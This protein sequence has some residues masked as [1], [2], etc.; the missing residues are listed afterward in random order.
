[1]FT[2]EE[3]AAEIAHDKQWRWGNSLFVDG[4]CVHV[5]EV[6][7]HT[8]EVIAKIEAMIAAQANSLSSAQ[9]VAPV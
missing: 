1:M 7:S 9:A 5:S 4:K 6:A 2:D 3:L 8:P